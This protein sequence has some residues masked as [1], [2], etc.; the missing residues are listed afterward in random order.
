[1]HMDYGNVVFSPHSKHLSAVMGTAAPWYYTSQA[2]QQHSREVTI[3]H[4]QPAMLSPL[5]GTRPAP[6]MLHSPQK[7]HGARATKSIGRAYFPVGQPMCVWHS[8]F[9]QD[10]IRR[11]LLIEKSHLLRNSFVRPRNRC[12]V[13]TKKA[14]QCI[15]MGTSCALGTAFLA[16][17]TLN[18]GNRRL[19]Y[20]QWREN[21]TRD[22]I[23]AAE[24]TEH[25]LPPTL[26]KNR[27]ELYVGHGSWALAFSCIHCLFQF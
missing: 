4:K 12:H 23:L 1:M 6:Y 26:H 16:P 3:S 19:R 7:S 25:K 11:W 20:G 5:P 27:V 24:G 15:Y 2:A 8:S 22:S 14:S 21:G 13:H 17:R 18:H 10:V 9:I